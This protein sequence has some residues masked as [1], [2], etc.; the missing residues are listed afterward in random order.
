MMAVAIDN[1]TM[2]LC[3][4]RDG[5]KKK[6]A[7]GGDLCAE[8]GEDQVLSQLVV[9]VHSSY[10][11]GGDGLGGG[12]GLQAA[13]H[14]GSERYKLGTNTNV[15]FLVEIPFGR[16][17]TWRRWWTAGRAGKNSSS[18][19]DHQVCS[20]DMLDLHPAFSNASHLGGGGGL[21]GGGLG[22]GWLQVAGIWLFW[23]IITA[24]S[25]ER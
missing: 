7:A 18:L 21:G 6:C 2:G 1:S 17:R 10:L 4:W 14:T 24:G 5:G 22:G 13:A 15:N 16:R 9:A 12:G 25:R 19:R 3:S 11:G 20:A 23:L 8:F